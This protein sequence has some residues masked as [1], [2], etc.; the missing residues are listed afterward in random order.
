MKLP[1]LSFFDGVGKVKIWSLFSGYK[2]QEAKLSETRINTGSQAEEKPNKKPNKG[3]VSLS[4]CASKVGFH[5]LST[6]QTLPSG[7]AGGYARE[8][9][10]ASEGLRQGNRPYRWPGPDSGESGG[11][12][13]KRQERRPAPW[14]QKPKASTEAQEIAGVRGEAE[15][16]KRRP[17][18]AKDKRPRHVGELEAPLLSCGTFCRHGRCDCEEE[19]GKV[20]K[21]GRDWCPYCGRKDSPAHMRRYARLIERGRQIEVIGYFVIEWPLAG[22]P[23]MRSQLELKQAEKTIKG[24]LKASFARGLTR[25]HFFGEPRCPGGCPPKK[26][27]QPV[28]L[29]NGSYLCPVCVECFELTD[30]SDLMPYN[31]HLN[32]ILDGLYRDDLEA[33]KAELREAFVCSNCGAR[34]GEPC[35]CPPGKRLIVTYKYRKSVAKKLHTLRYIARPTFLAWQWDEEL[36]LELKG[37]R[38]TSWWGYGKWN[39]PPAWSLERSDGKTAEL[40]SLEKGECPDC[41]SKIEW[42]GLRR[43]AWYLAHG[44]EI[45]ERPGG[46]VRLK[47]RRRSRARE[48]GEEG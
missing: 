38:T 31:P 8:S 24:V 42:G 14:E 13:G 43:I 28:A 40:L 16:G 27:S 10:G 2:E 37:F 1:T 41:R 32:V 4:P 39:L 20:L 3:L 12:Q 23:G 17:A 19:H 34:P 35:G 5:D 29:E 44:Y 30:C 11:S 15:W 47:W 22:R 21:C 48:P 7:R 25:W 33:I 6:L 45:E 26:G 36:A 18:G 46:Y 9:Q